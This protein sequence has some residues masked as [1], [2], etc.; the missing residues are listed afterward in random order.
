VHDALATL[1]PSRRQLLI[2]VYLR[3]RSLAD[4]ADELGI[5]VGTA[6]SR[7]HYALHALRRVLEEPAA[8]QARAA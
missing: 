8:D 1:S 3:G 2:E 6:K 4:V 5:P 7:I